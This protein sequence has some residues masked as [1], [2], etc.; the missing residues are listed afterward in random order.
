MSS[1][2]HL[3]SLWKSRFFPL[4]R[5]RQR[6]TWQTNTND[7]SFFFKWQSPG[8]QHFSL[9]HLKHNDTSRGESHH[10]EAACVTCVDAPWLRWSARHRPE[11]QQAPRSWWWP[12]AST[13]QACPPQVYLVRWTRQHKPAALRET[14]R[15][16]L[17]ELMKC[18]I[19]FLTCVAGR[20][21]GVLLARCT[22]HTNIQVWV[23][24]LRRAAVTCTQRSPL[25]YYDTL[26]FLSPR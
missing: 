6:T 1:I 10:V 8:L 17:H 15:S 13:R 25:W 9:T 21:L 2:T 24:K 18:L 5:H 3:C 22:R 7:L 12:P 16:L 11:R 23:P 14:E 20:G 26:W 4:C 19:L